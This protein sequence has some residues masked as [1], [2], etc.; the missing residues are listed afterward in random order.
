MGVGWWF[1][2]KLSLGP[3]ACGCRLQTMRRLQVPGCS[4]SRDAGGRERR[5]KR[6]LKVS[7]PYSGPGAG[8]SSNDGVGCRKRP[9]APER[10]GR[11]G[12]YRLAW[13][14]AKGDE[15]ADEEAAEEEEEEVTEEGRTEDDHDERLEQCSASVSELCRS[16][17]LAT[18]RRK[19]RS[20]VGKEEKKA[21]ADA[22]RKRSARSA[23]A[24][25]AK[26]DTVSDSGGQKGL[27]SSS[28]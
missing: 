15:E 28:S 16:P 18:H 4:Q 3:L 13:Q 1:L 12:G 5:R 8:G 23:E 10:R 25:A 22:S 26:S 14:A 11:L 17:S 7:C 20:R 27:S 19:V 24:D 6:S 21:L 2:D 9:D